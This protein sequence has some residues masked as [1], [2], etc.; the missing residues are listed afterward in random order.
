MVAGSLLVLALS[1]VGPSVQTW[2]GTAPSGACVGKPVYID[3]LGTGIYYCNAG[4]WASV[5]PG[6]GGGGTPAGS[7]GQVQFNASGAFAADADLTFSAATNTLQSTNVKAV[8]DLGWTTNRFS[9]AELPL[10]TDSVGSGITAWTYAQGTS[11]SGYVV[12]LKNNGAGN[13]P[14]RATSGLSFND[15]TN[16]LTAAGGFVGALTGN[17]STATT[18]SSTTSLA[19]SATPTWCSAGQASRGISANGDSGGCFAPTAAASSNVEILHSAAATAGVPLQNSGTLTLNPAGWSTSDSLSYDTPVTL[20]FVP[21]ARTSTTGVITA[22]GWTFTGAGGTIT[23]PDTGASGTTYLRGDGTWATPGGGGSPAGSTGQV[24]FN[25]AGAFAA[26]VDLSHSTTNRTTYV[27]IGV[28][29]ERQTTH[30]VS[31]AAGRLKSYAFGHHGTNSPAVPQ[32]VDGQTSLEFHPLPMSLAIDDRW[33]CAMPAGFGTTTL[34][35]TGGTTVTA[36]INGR[37]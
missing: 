32:I 7:N 1:V 18:S 14:P 36:G 9:G 34:I 26:S 8:T 2:V 31:P 13:A 17:A 22:G 11:N 37:F 21:T 33:G 3:Y 10:M 30:P 16:V 20:K 25:N 29:N 5:T 15:S 27:G 12:Y 35:S 24:Q 6:G 28:E 23:I 4:T 19:L